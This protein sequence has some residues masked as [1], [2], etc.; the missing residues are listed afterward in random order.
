MKYPDDYVNKVICGDCLE[1]MKGIPDNS[2]DLVLTDP[3]YNVGVDYG[4]QT[5]DNRDDFI[6]W[7]TPIFKETQRISKSILITTGHYRLA[8]YAII[9]KWKWLIAWHKPASIKRSPVGFTNF[10]PIAL[11]G[12]GSNGHVDIFKAPILVDGGLNGHP[13]PKPLK[14][15]LFQLKMFP[16]AQTVLDPFLG[17]GTTAVACKQLGRR[18]IGIEISPEYCKIAEQRLAQEVLI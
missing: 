14:W 7:M 5:N 18:Y 2:V 10:E 9:E 11:W 3:P 16:N 17:S 8:D 12:K 15:A 13:C 6:E 4:E 1:I